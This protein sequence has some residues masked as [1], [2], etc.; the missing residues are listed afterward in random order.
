MDRRN[1]NITA[2]DVVESVR[3]PRVGLEVA[4]D[5]SGV[6]EALLAADRKGLCTVLLAKGLAALDGAV[7]G[8]LGGVESRR[9]GLVVAL[10][11]AA[12]G[13]GGAGIG[14]V[15]GIAWVRAWGL[16]LAGSG[17]VGLVGSSGAIAGLVEEEVLAR[18]ILFDVAGAESLSTWQMPS[19]I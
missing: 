4:R 5:N 18:G 10:D 16:A 13:D 19:S 15:G 7:S 17:R 8:L 3:A 11:A 6:Q 12:A 1:D 2:S 9:L 14:W